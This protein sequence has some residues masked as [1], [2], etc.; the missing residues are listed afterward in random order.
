MNHREVEEVL[1]ALWTCHEKKDHSIET[2]RK[3]CHIPIEQELLSALEENDLIAFEGE[4]ILL[5]K[6]G[7]IRA[8]Q[9]I[10]RH[11]LAERLF[12]DV[13]NMP[14]H[15]IE[16][17]ACEFEHLIAPQVEESI[18]T[19]LGHPRE[20]PHGARIPRG[21]CCLEAKETVDNVVIPLTRMQAGKTAKVA[22]ISTPN[23]P[24][25][26]K[27]ISFG[28]TPGVMLKV[29]QKTPSY[30]ISCGQTE[31]ALEEDVVRDI[32]VWRETE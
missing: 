2:L 1:E 20:C 3:L 22:Y 8:A 10:R 14:I 21:K 25:L 17:G 30:V 29:H 16:S 32:Y 6:K 19:L 11:R 4:L 5:T 23:H 12:V 28:I 13:L 15:Q 18:C 26:H 24:R 9:I 31:L 7:E 27:L